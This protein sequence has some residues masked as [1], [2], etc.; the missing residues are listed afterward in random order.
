MAAI[1]HKMLP[2]IRQ[3]K[4]SNIVAKLERFENH[5]IENS[6][7]EL[8]EITREIDQLLEELQGTIV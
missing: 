2:M 5:R 3:L 7:E 6:R 4:A 1:A 8:E